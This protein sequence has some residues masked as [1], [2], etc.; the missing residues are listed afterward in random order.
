M[1]SNISRTCGSGR[2]PEAGA[3]AALVGSVLRAHRGDEVDEL[4]ELLGLLLSLLRGRRHRRG[5]VHER[6]RD[7]VAAEAVADVR[8]VRT[9]G[10]A[11]L[12]DLVAAQ[13]ARRGQHL[14]ALLV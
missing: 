2:V 13:A 12:A 14:R 9:E 11:V 6:A 1:R 4:V 10:V 5:G 3:P 8:Q 7:R